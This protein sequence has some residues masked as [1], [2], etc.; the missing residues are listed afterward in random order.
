MRKLIPLAMLATFLS[1]CGT[2]LDPNKPVDSAG[3]LANIQ[4]AQTFVSVATAGAEA[5]ILSKL[6]FCVTNADKIRQ[7]EAIATEALGQAKDIAST[8]ATQAQT[9]L[10]VAMNALLIFSSLA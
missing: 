9:L 1:G 4:T 8:D 10:R 2:G 6:A 7:A 3:V 5:C